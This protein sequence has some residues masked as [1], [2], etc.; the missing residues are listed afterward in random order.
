MPRTLEGLRALPG[1]GRYTAAAIAS[2]AFGADVAVL[3]GNVK[4]VL[5]RVLDFRDD[6]KTPRGEKQLWVLAQS[7]VPA[8]RAADYN[9]AI[10]DLGA[11]VCTPRAPQCPVCPL[12]AMCTARNLGVQ[13]ERPVVKRRP[14]ALPHHTLVAGVIYKGRRVLIVQR[15]T[16]EL[17]GGL[18]AFPGGRRAG[19]EPLAEG[20]RRIVHGEWGLE[21]TVGAR[22]QTLTHSFT[23]F[24]IT[25]HV[26][27]CEWQN[28]GLKRRPGVKW[29]RLSAL[30]HYPMGKVDRQIAKGLNRD[31]S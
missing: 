1:I 15:P 29:V 27:E 21:I 24:R 13:L 3:D 25:Q 30:K 11:T 23:H 18:W 7:L 5:A 12:R 22:R 6:V 4:R 19:R 16:G 8:G 9:Q 31:T 14:T 17:L 20:L 10:M 26:F 2:I 28:G